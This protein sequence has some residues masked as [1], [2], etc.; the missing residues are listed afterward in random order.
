MPLPSL[1]TALTA[2]LCTAPSIL[3]AASAPK[4]GISLN[5]SAPTGVLKNTW[6]D[7]VGYGL[8]FFAEWELDSGHAFRAAYDGTYFPKKDDKAPVAGFNQ[9][10]VLGTETS[11]RFC[12]HAVTL[13]YVFFPIK[14]WGEGFHVLVGAGAMK[15]DRASDHT[16]K[17]ANASPLTFTTLH[18]TGTKLVTQAGIGYNFQ[19]NWGVSAKYS[20][21]RANDHTLATVQAG[22]NLKF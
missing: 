18:E 6:N 14:A 2:L 7:S 12:Q 5:G 20:M 19:T 4:L 8:G 3:S 1:R 21:I 11:S 15:F 22:I 17:Y 9:T 10:N 16:V 13:N